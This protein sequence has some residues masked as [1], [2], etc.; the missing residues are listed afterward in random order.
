LPSASPRTAA[1]ISGEQQPA[2]PK[3]AALAENCA[4][5]FDNQVAV[6]LKGT[7][8][9]LRQAPAAPQRR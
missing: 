3:L 6:N 1:S 8:N 7:F 4:T 9:T 2:S 5:L